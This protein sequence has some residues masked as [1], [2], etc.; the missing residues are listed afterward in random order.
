MA[1]NCCPRTTHPNAEVYKNY[2]NLIA[3]K[4]K[5]IVCTHIHVTHIYV[6]HR[7]YLEGKSLYS[8][9]QR[10]PAHSTHRTWKVHA[11]LMAKEPQTSPQGQRHSWEQDPAYLLKKKWNIF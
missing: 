8:Q 3:L 6:G 11:Q 10:V 4:I 2:L 1:K 7:T 5:S 9:N